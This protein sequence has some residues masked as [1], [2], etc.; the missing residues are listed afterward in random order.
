MKK[1]L[2]IVSLLTAVMVV[3]VTQAAAGTT[4][5]ITVT[6]TVPSVVSVSLSSSSWSIGNVVLGET[7]ATAEDNFVA[8]NDGNVPEDFAILSGNSANWT[9]GAAAGSEVFAMKAKGGDLLSWTAINAGQTLDTNVAKDGTV[10]FGL[11]LTAP[12][13]TAYVDT[14]QSI[15][16]TVTASSTP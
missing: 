15:S 5:G 14:Q 13:A 12:T 2:L 8:T 10:A 7:Q 9:S 11:Q 1:I 3:S 6:V 4:A 16:V